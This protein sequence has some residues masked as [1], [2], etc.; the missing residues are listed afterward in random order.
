MLIPQM[1]ISGGV[2]ARAFKLSTR[3]SEKMH[4]ILI[5]PCAN[6][7]HRRLGWLGT[8]L[9]HHS[10]ATGKTTMILDSKSFRYSFILR[11]VLAAVILFRT[12]AD[13]FNSMLGEVSR[14]LHMPPG[15]LT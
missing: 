1:L 10:Y 6:L 15:Q 7:V 2:L 3:L 9:F 5:I 4:Q 8:L 14:I 12:Q 11:P 13:L